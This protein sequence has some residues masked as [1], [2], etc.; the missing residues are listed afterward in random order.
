MSKKKG[1]LQASDE[2]E[3]AVVSDY[4]RLCFAEGVKPAEAFRE[5]KHR[6][7]TGKEDKELKK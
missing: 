6:L 4:V 2:V 5:L 3:Q 1:V 7:R